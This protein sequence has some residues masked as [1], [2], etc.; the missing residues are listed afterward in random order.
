MLEILKTLDLAT[1]NKED[2]NVIDNKEVK[3]IT[4][5][6]NIANHLGKNINFYGFSIDDTV[7]FY[8]ECE[9]LLKEVKK[10]L[11]SNQY[12]LESTRTTIAVNSFDYDKIL[13][14]TEHVMVYLPSEKNIV[15]V[16]HLHIEFKDT[17]KSIKNIENQPFT[18]WKRENLLDVELCDEY[19]EQSNMELFLTQ[20][21]KEVYDISPYRFLKYFNFEIVKDRYVFYKKDDVAI[22]VNDLY[23]IEKD[24]GGIFNCSYYDRIKYVGR[25]LTKVLAEVPNY[26]PID[27]GKQK[28]QL[29]Y[30]IPSEKELKAE[31][32]FPFEFNYQRLPGNFDYVPIIQSFDKI[33][34]MEYI[35]D[36]SD[37]DEIEC[38]EQDENIF[39]NW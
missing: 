20:L 18:V 30:F 23:A 37:I 29:K 6:R 16:L 26:Y 22:M 31:R 11:T 32:L 5:I 39:N 3:C 33:G 8:E 2:S 19:G 21:C 7:T 14:L 38:N 27:F 36:W 13:V 9:G 28:L 10:N 25:V 34:P 4:V 24:E 35:E 12:E 1:I 15:S 17:A